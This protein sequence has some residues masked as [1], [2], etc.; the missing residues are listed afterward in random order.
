M[1]PIILAILIAL[2]T[3]VATIIFFYK[4]G[5]PLEIK[6]NRISDFILE[7][8]L[9]FNVSKSYTFVYEKPNSILIYENKSLIFRYS[10]NVEEDIV[11]EYLSSKIVSQFGPVN[12][13]DRD[14]IQLRR[15]FFHVK[16]LSITNQNEK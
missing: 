5:K 12:L 6:D 13:T 14:I 16:S 7:L 10:C 2:V 3:V 8:S 15:L 9:D 4:N 1:N 11:I